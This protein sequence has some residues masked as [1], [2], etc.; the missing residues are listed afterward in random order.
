MWGEKRSALFAPSIHRFLH[1]T[2]P[3]I[4]L[5]H[6]TSIHPSNPSFTHS[7]KEQTF[8]LPFFSS[9]CIFMNIEIMA[10]LHSNMLQACKIKPDP[11]PQV[12]VALSASPATMTRGAG[13]GEAEVLIAQVLDLHQELDAHRHDLRPRDA[14]NTLFG[15]LVGICTKTISEAVTDQVRPQNSAFSSWSPDSIGPLR[16]WHYRHSSLFT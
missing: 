10:F 15:R 5:L 9:D 12:T 4:R 3:C 7:F 14:I 6:F 8:H 11:E 13:D 16:T 1:L 2:S